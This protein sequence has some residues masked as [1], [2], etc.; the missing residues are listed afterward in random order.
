MKNFTIYLKPTTALFFLL[1]LGVG[2]CVA[3]QPCDKD[4][5]C[6]E[7]MSCNLENKT[8]KDST[9]SDAKPS[10]DAMV[11]P[12][13]AMVPPVPDAMVPPVATCNGLDQQCLDI[14][15][16]GWTGPVVTS[17]A[18]N[19]QPPAACTG[20]YSDMLGVF[21]TTIN[22][23]DTCAC[24]CGAP[25]SL[26]CGQPSLGVW[27]GS[28]LECETN[29]CISGNC[30]SAS[31]SIPPISLVPLQG[32]LR[33][34]P[35]LRLTMPDAMATCPAPTADGTTTA[36]LVDTVSLC[37]KTT[38]QELI[39]GCSPGQTCA[40]YTPEAGFAAPLCIVKQGEHICPAGNF[41]ERTLLYVGIQ[42]Q[43]SC[44]ASSCQ[45]DA[46]TTCHGDAI[47]REGPI[48]FANNYIVREVLNTNNVCSQT[49]I[50][51]HVQWHLLGVDNCSLQAGTI[52]T[53]SGSVM[54]LGTTTLCCAP[55]IQ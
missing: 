24:S 51:T 19:G 5:P 50:K 2:A 49:P 54:S 35:V 55:Q 9:A 39:E 16:A 17:I 25:T 6:P 52:P 13:D 4:T 30:I 37:G 14:T 44:D 28:H 7:G 27:T 48:G 47:L 29:T 53:T 20:A 22:K 31:Q 33:S 8:C 46:P 43:R 40:N 38:P 34:A 36:D 12:T 23:N 1:L 26:T 15:P 45:C 11:P 41:S 3:N 18:A 10:S 21:G 42:D 32:N